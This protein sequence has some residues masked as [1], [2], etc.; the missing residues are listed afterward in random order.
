MVVTLH[1]TI[2]SKSYGSRYDAYPNQ[3]YIGYFSKKHKCWSVVILDVKV[4]RQSCQRFYKIA[5]PDEGKRTTNGQ[6]YKSTPEC[7]HS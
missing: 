2:F 5:I 1:K 6:K 7:L 3:L 4:K